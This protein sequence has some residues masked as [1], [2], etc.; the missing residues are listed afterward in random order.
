[1]EDYVFTE[2]QYNTKN[3]EKH[4]HIIWEDL[5]RLRGFISTSSILT[6]LYSLKIEKDID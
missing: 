6:F 1:M 3:T 4:E 2:N 5:S